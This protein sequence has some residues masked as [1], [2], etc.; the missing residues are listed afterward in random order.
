[1]SVTGEQIVA[2]VRWGTGSRVFQA[3]LTK[4]GDAKIAINKWTKNLRDLLDQAHGR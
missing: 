4:M 2:V 1:M 3:G